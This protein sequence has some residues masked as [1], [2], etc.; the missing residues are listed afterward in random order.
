LLWPASFFIGFETSL[1]IFTL[2][3]FG[4]VILGLRVP[5]L[6]LLSVGVLCVI[7]PL[8]RILL[9]TGGWLRWNT[10][11]YLLMGMTIVYLPVALRITDLHN[12]VL[13]AFTLL[14]ALGLVITPDFEGG[15]ISILN[16]MSVFGLSVFFLRSRRDPELFIWLGLV[17]GTISALGGIA[18]YVHVQNLPYINPNA[19]S[20]FPLTGLFSVCLSLLFAKQRSVVQYILGLLAVISVVIA[21]LSAS[22]GA[23]LVAFVCLCF[24]L[25]QMGDFVSRW[26]IVVGGLLV[27]AALILSFGDYGDYAVHRL[28]KLFNEERSLAD[29]TS[30][31]SELALSGFHL[32][33]DH[34]LGVGTGGFRDSFADL[35]VNVAMRGLGRNAHSAWIMVLAENGILGLIAF[36]SY[37]LSFALLGWSRRE[38]RLLGLGLLVTV[39]LAVSFLSREF[40][41]KGPWLLAAGAAVILHRAYG[42]WPATRHHATRVLRPHL[43]APIKPKRDPFLLVPQSTETAP[44]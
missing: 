43:A 44:P 35:R 41:G 33:L 18:F 37:I 10:F 12:R 19:W 5:S 28:S 20:F 15:V 40:Q 39:V 21:F 36:L 23:M 4:G 13:Q 17:N 9:M 6:G 27:T 7:D 16:I 3:A 29:R 38:E 25:F 34:P 32:F 1:T 22:R 30:G 42:V 8:T 11:N 24:V 26:T 31:R 2:A 14:L